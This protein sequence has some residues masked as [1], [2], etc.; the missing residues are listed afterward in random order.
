MFGFYTKLHFE[1]LVDEKRKCLLSSA[2]TP[3]YFDPK[4]DIKLIKSSMMGMDK[5]TKAIIG[6]YIDFLSMDNFVF[7]NLRDIHLENKGI[8]S[9]PQAYIAHLIDE[10]ATTALENLSYVAERTGESFR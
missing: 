1:N 6:G 9:D 8:L 2:N 4:M 3:R 7:N 5:Q 10:R